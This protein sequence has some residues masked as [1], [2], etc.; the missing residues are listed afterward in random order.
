[1]HELD[2]KSKRDG[3]DHASEKNDHLM[4]SCPM[5]K[6]NANDWENNI[7]GTRMKGENFVSITD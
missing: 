4:M 1:M 7:M 6:A 2:C 5:S 3:K